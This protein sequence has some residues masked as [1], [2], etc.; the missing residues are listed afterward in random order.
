MTSIINKQYSET[1][2]KRKN[3]QAGPKKKKKKQKQKP[4]WVLDERVALGMV[5]A[6]LDPVKGLPLDHR[7]RPVLEYILQHTDRES[8]LRRVEYYHSKHR[9]SGRLYASNSLQRLSSKVRNLCIP[10][11]EKNKKS[12]DVD[13]ANAHPEILWQVF[14]KHGI[15]A[16]TM[17]EYITD[18]DEIILKILKLYPELIREDVKKA[19][20]TAQNQGCYKKATNGRQIEFLD[21]FT[22]ELQRAASELYK[23]DEY[24]EI[25]RHVSTDTRN[26]SKNLLGSFIFHICEDV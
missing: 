13:I 24:S 23:L 11:D 10:N 2:K 9:Q 26:K 18:R 1:R 3:T 4:V 16:A 25:R 20:I 7:D 15:G 19:F 6:C 12:I 8:G 21:E 5:E 22:V 14:N 17:K